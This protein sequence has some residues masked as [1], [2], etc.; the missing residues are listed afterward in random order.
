M[1]STCSASFAHAQLESFLSFKMAAMF[2]ECVWWHGF[3]TRRF[4]AMGWDNTAKRFFRF[5]WNEQKG[6]FWKMKIT[7]SACCLIT[8][9]SV[10]LQTSR[11]WQISC[12]DWQEIIQDN[13]NM[14][15]TLSDIRQPFTCSVS[16]RSV[17]HSLKYVQLQ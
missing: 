6:M 9:T 15:I 4:A 2:V 16:F 12:S 5:P 8:H 14:H 1:S 3:L 17:V 7:T 11:V 10:E 13:E